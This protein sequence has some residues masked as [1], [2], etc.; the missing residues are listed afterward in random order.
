MTRT[1]VL[2]AAFRCMVKLSEIST[3]W[4]FWSF[5]LFVLYIYNQKQQQ[6]KQLITT[7]TTT[8]ALLACLN[9][10]SVESPVFW[11]VAVGYYKHIRWSRCLSQHTTPIVIGHAFSPFC[12]PQPQPRPPSSVIKSSDTSQGLKVLLSFAPGRSKAKHRLAESVQR[13]S[14]WWFE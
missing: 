13:V 2:F 1:A 11:V 3:F 5:S 12:I 7:A 9:Q 6:N 8:N 10:E 4:S 14:K